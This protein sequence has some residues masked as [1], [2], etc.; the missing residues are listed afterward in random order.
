MFD[1]DK[2]VYPAGQYLV[3]EDIP[4]GKYLLKAEE[5]KFG[6][7]S[8]YENYQKFKE[9]EMIMYQ[10][11]ETEYHLS[12]RENGLFIVVSNATINKI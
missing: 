4:M 6:D 3:G 11:F 5:E 7:V 8:I 9:D 10:G 12:L 1:K 2:G